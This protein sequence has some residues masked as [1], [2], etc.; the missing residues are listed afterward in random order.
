M[1]VVPRAPCSTV[2][3]VN[4]PSAEDSQR[5]PLEV[6]SPALRLTHFHPVRDDEG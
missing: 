6:G 4:S 1:T 5:T 2:S 3:T